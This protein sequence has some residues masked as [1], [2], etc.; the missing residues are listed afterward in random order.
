MTILVLGLLSGLSLTLQSDGTGFFPIPDSTWVSPGSSFAVVDGD[1]LPAFNSARGAVVGLQVSPSPASGV[2]VLLF[3]DTLTVGRPNSIELRLE[4]L[5]RLPLD[6]RSSHSAS[7]AGEGL[8]ISGV[9]RLG[10]SLGS[11]GGLVQGTRLSLDGTLAPGVTVRG[12]ITDESLPLGAASSEAVSELDRVNLFVEGSSWTTELGDMERERT[13]DGLTPLRYRRSLS[14]FAGTVSPAEALTGGIGYGITG[15]RRYHTVFLTQ[16][17][18]QGPYAFAPSGVTP[19]SERIHLDGVL[20]GRGSSADYTVDYPGGR[21]TF[22]A[23]RLIRRDQRVEATCYREGDGFRRGVMTGAVTAGSGDFT[24]ESGFFREGDDTGSPLGFVMSPE[25]E[26]V[27]RNAGE[28]PA[29]AWLSGAAYLGEGEGSY[30]VDS[31]GH[32]VYLGPGGG[33]WAVTFQR[34]PEGPGDYVYDSVTGGYRWV[35]EGEG[36]HLPRKYIDI[37]AMR[38]LGGVA[39]HGVYGVLSAEVSGY[40]SKRE[41]NLFNTEGTTRAGSFVSTELVFEPWTDG[42]GLFARGR[43]VSDGFSFPD[44]SDSDN[45]LSRW[46]LPAGFTGNDSYT[47]AGLASEKANLSAGRRFLSDGG[48]VEIVQ[49]GAILPRERFTLELTGKAGRRAGA[50]E[51]LDGNRISAG[52]NLSYRAGAFTPFS[53]LSTTRESWMDSL[54]GWLHD[55]EFGTLLEQGSWDFRVFAGG[56]LDRRGGTGLPDRI[57]RAGVSGGGRG[58]SWSMDGTYNHSTSWFPAGGLSRADAIT[59][60]LSL[61]GPGWWSHTDYSAGGYLGRSVEIIYT[62]VGEGNG[63]YSYDPETGEYYPDPGGEYDRSFQSGEGEEKVLECGLKSSGYFRAEGVG[64]DGSLI[65]QASDPFDRLKT[66][67]LAGALDSDSPGE[68]SVSLSPWL[69]WEEGVLRRL[70]LRLS[71]SDL[72]ETLSGSGR[73]RSTERSARLTPLL[74]LHQVVE[75]ELSGRVS[76]KDDDLYGMRSITGLLVSADP[77]YLPTPG[78]TAGV[79]LSVDSRRES[80][81]LLSEASFGVRPHVSVNTGGWITSAT[82]SVA[83]IPGEGDLPSWFFDGVNR[84]VTLDGS[85]NAGRNLGRWIRLSL[86]FR[87][88]RPAGGEWTRTGGLEGTVSF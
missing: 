15:A 45:D 63:D 33:E 17:G 9:K 40:V 80:S 3:F 83:R 26:E 73:R 61:N 42:P 69:S 22:T 72:R 44:E 60:G 38:E 66:F 4:P 20:L 68:W 70:T 46:L 82:Y 39:L 53:S 12:A 76:R 77:R 1:T 52:S 8:Y 11:D 25:A 13:G 71:A 32:Y 18:V 57:A 6:I 21:L 88:R 19:G 16:E 65:L 51:L 43:M 59:L 28:N 24:I 30:S 41:G 67:T 14:G 58:A 23:A 81:T 10:V 2:P 74:R 56:T 75:L 84:G 64:L 48:S 5:A 49:A 55:G 50:L 54:S 37:P 47:E 35:D 62:W 34:P 87:G 7:P 27:L 29:E 85:V 36:T 86:F 78:I 79:E 31:L